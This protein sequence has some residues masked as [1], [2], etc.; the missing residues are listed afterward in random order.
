[1][2]EDNL[3][4]LSDILNTWWKEEDTECVDLRT[5]A[6]PILKKVTQTNLRT[7]DQ[8]AYEALSTKS[9]QQCYK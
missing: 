6:P 9:L 2:D 8:H 7:T 5:R 4:N 3:S 1:M